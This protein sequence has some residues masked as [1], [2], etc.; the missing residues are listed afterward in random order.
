MRPT[1]GMPAHNLVEGEH[2]ADDL[3]ELQ[4]GAFHWQVRAAHAAQFIHDTARSVRRTAGICRWPAA[5]STSRLEA[6]AAH[7]LAKYRERHE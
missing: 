2:L 1:K 5:H 4:R 7:D 6:A 3:D